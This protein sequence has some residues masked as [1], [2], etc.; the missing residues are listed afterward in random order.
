M[1][2]QGLVRL[3]KHL[4]GRQPSFG[5]KVAATRAY[6]FKG[7]PANELNWTQPD[8]D[9]GSLDDVAAPHRE[10]PTLSAALTDPQLNYNTIPLLMSAF[11]GEQA[12]PSSVSGPAL[13]WNTA[14]S[15][16][17][18]DEFDP[19]TY[20]FGDDVLTDWFQMGD[21]VLESVDITIPE[22]LGP[23]TTD[24]TWKFGS[25][26]STGSSDSPV[27]GSVPEDLDIELNPAI[28]YGKDLS[29]F[30]A[31]DVAGLDTG[32]I[33]D[34]LA[35]GVLRLSGDIDEKRYAN[36]TQSF[37]A[38]AFARATRVIE[39]E[40][41]FAKTADTVGTGSESD[42]WMAD[43]AVDRYLRLD[44][45]SL[46]E[47]DTN[48]PYSWIVNLPFRYIT[49]VE[50]EIGGNTKVI[51]TGHAFYDPEDLGGVFTSDVVCTL[52]DADLGTAVS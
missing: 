26:S 47:A 7:V 9:T 12:A 16:T 28:V 4:F 17:S 11:F 1:P 3:R 15:S 52:T 24:M 19:Y 20:G 10:A 48:V 31:D 29:I 44:F 39:V 43:Q 35:S 51:L 42:H 18:L 50:G 46:S 45:E 2:V 40:F 38:S 34:A 14:P 41:T 23:V 32:K 21:G 6:P 37:D 25:T 27:D 8:I 30:I 5:E 22:G 49:R 13:L 36:G 33:V